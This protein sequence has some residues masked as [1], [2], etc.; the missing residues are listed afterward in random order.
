MGRFLVTTVQA[1][2]HHRNRVIDAKDADDAKCKAEAMND[3][4][5][6]DEIPGTR[7]SE[8]FVDSITE[9]EVIRMTPVN[10]S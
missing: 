8:S 2:W 1:D 6:W 4:A 3:W 10:E 5:E 7:K 9:V